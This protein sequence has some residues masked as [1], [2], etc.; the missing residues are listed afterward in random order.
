LHL[1]RRHSRR[2]R[3]DAGL[4]PSALRDLVSGSQ[5]LDSTGRGIRVGYDVKC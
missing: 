1:D 2:H 4:P 3:V 5:A